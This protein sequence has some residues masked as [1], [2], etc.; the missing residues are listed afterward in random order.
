MTTSFMSSLHVG[1]AVSVSKFN[2]MRSSIQ[3]E[4]FKG[5]FGNIGFGFKHI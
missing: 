1:A 2:E 5:L 3:H 4:Q